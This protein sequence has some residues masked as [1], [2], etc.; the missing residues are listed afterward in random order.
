MFQ[1]K[2]GLSGKGMRARVLIAGLLAVGFCMAGLSAGGLRAVEWPG[3][4]QGLAEGQTRTVTDLMGRR[5]TL[6]SGAPRLVVTAP[7]DCEI[8][9]ALGAGDLLVGRGMDCNY[10]ESV[11]SLPVVNSG[12]TTNVEQ[13]IALEPD[14]VLMNTM[15]Q[16]LEQVSAL[17]AAGIPV[18]ATDTTDIQGVYR[19]IALVGEVAGKEAQAETLVAQMQQ[20]FAAL[21]E[22]AEASRGKTVYFEVS[23]LQY[24]LWTAGKGTFLDEMA[25]LCGL[26]NLFL[27]VEGW[28]QISQEQVLE[29]NPDLIVT[30]TPEMDGQPSPDQEIR[31][32]AGWEKLEAVQAGKILTAFGDIFMRP[33]P[34]LTEAAEQLAA[35]AADEAP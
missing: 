23:P 20:D 31:E 12:M 10:P 1:G 22:R 34:R 24:G 3:P 11:L 17:E 33:G 32:R 26:T 14:A 19:A 13:I 7:A 5:C 2:K 30:F 4:A 25:S 16:P 15:A 27:D 8:L 18:I 35:F 9:V 6:E 21:T 28:A 29:R